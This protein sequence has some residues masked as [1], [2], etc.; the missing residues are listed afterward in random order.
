MATQ[1]E[2]IEAKLR[3]GTSVLELVR[4]GFPSG[5]V[6]SAKSRLQTPPVSFP[7]SNGTSGNHRASLSNGKIDPTKQEHLPES[8]A[9]LSELDFYG[10]FV[11]S[12]EY[13]SVPEGWNFRSLRGWNL[14]NHSMLPVFDLK[15]ADGTLCG[16]LLGFA[17]GENG[18]LVNDTLSVPFPTSA[19]VTPD[20]FEKF[21]YS[22]GGRFIFIIL[23]GEHAR[24]YLDPCGSLAAVYDTE[25]KC[26]ASTLGLVVS[27]PTK[28]TKSRGISRAF[29]ESN[30]FYP[31]GLTAISRVR[32]LLV[33]HYL[34]LDSWE[35]VRHWLKTPLTRVG[36]EEIMTLVSTIASVI[37]RNIQA[38]LEQYPTYL[39]LTAGRDSRM[40]LACSRELAEQATFLTFDYRDTDG[41]IDGPT[42]LR[43]SRKLSKRF[44]LKH[45]IIPIH[46]PPNQGLKQEYLL[47]IGYAGHWGK[48]R[49][50][51]DSCARYLD[52]N[53]ALLIGYAGEVGRA[54]YWYRFPYDPLLLDGPNWKPDARQLLTWLYL[55]NNEPFVSPMND[56]LKGIPDIDTYMLLDQ[57]YLEQRM[58]CW[59]S[60][61]LYGAAPF[62]LVMTPLCHREVIEAM[63]RLPVEYRRDQ[64]LVEDI[65]RI[66]WPELAEVPFQK[67]GR[68]AQPGYLKKLYQISKKAIK[69]S[70]KASVHPW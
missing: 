63:M 46:W 14:W 28:H 54:Y 52:L 4:A 43:I 55:P 59:A 13:R 30:Q 49:D 22:F 7:I 27:D 6:Y 12:Q 60:P 70:A 23:N 57:L 45:K 9:S 69:A 53:Q 26:V 41:G 1:T 18:H 29:P 21:A 37:K 44:G 50:F 3:S 20:Q 10:Q 15:T 31:A 16:W 64:V 19:S 67:T 33:N 39:P 25:K 40:M 36:D 66:G 62:Q 8:K 35:P 24:L 32:R 42:D 51:Y 58:G 48:A 34:D 17:I 11:V 68:Q 2:E 5:E 65:M 61:H 38:V 56:W 47:R